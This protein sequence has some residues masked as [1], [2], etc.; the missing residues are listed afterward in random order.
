MSNPPSIPKP[1]PA[2]S[3]SDPSLFGE[4]ADAMVAYLAPFVD[5]MERMAKWMEGQGDAVAQT[6]ALTGEAVSHIGFR[7][8][9]ENSGSAKL[10]I[11]TNDRSPY[12]VVWGESD[13][14]MSASGEEVQ[15]SYS[16]SYTGDATVLV[17]VGSRIRSWSSDEGQWSFDL[18]AL[19]RGLEEFVCHDSRNITGTIATLPKNTLTLFDVRGGNTIRGDIRELSDMERLTYFRLQGDNTLRGPTHELV[20]TQI[21]YFLVEGDNTITPTNSGF[22]DRMSKFQL[23]GAGL[24]QDQVDD[25]LRA[26]E[27]VTTWLSPAQV[28]LT[29]RNAAP[30]SAGVNS[31]TIIR[32]NGA[33]EVLYTGGPT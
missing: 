1:P 13:F 19:P 22:P 17:P 16:G 6:F 5:A 30:S 11:V 8:A 7:F 2:P 4:R 24:D 12:L 27:S 29:G 15:K 28:S 3:L 26:L 23:R 10:R 20:G 25:M 33:S 18:T 32:G 9:L 21:T 31:A 14:S